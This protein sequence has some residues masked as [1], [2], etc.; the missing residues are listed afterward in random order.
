MGNNQFAYCFNNPVNMND[1]SGHWPKWMT[2]VKN[3]VTNKIIK[4]ISQ[5]YDNVK[6]DVINYDSSNES[7]DVVFKSNYF[8]C[9]KGTLVVITPFDASVS[10]GVIGL[11]SRQKTSNMLNHEYGHKLQLNNMGML[12]Y[13]SDVAIPSFTANMLDRFGKLPYDYYGSPWEAEA[14]MLGGVNRMHNNTPW[15]KEAYSSYGDLIMLFFE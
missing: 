8:S 5:I 1:S 10:F 13:I 6:Q 2:A 14:D 12:T 15:P 9:Y 3:W 7:E 11:S 4:P